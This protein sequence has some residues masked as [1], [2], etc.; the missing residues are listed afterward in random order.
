MEDDSLAFDFQAGKVEQGVHGLDSAARG[1]GL[2]PAE[3]WREARYGPLWKRAV[4]VAELP[5]MWP[6]YH[7]LGVL[8]CSSRFVGDN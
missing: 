2:S 6:M 7:T 1:Y 4:L 3:Q 8:L 5:F